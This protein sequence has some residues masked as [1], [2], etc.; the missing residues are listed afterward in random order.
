MA[1]T[2]ARLI[3]LNGPPGVGKSTQARRYLDEHPFALIAELDVARRS[4][5]R[6]QDDP[7]RATAL[8][9]ALTLAAADRHLAAGG[10]D[11]L[12]PQY[13]GNPAFHAEAEA[14]AAR[15]GATFHEFVLMDD[16]DTVIARFHKRNAAAQDPAHVEAGALVEQLGGDDTLARMYDRLLQVINA[17]PG[18]HVVH[19]PEGPI[20]EVLATWQ[21][22]LDA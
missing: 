22:L 16:R 19:C 18:A 7:V 4:L 3:V 17:R 20:D 1:P 21:E 5:G 15:H 9:R 8:A 2:V 6:W 12:L 10:H 13:L 14:L 11:V